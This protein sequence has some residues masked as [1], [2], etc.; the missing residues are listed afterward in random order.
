MSR[1]DETRPPP[2]GGSAASGFRA[3]VP[4]ILI[5]EDAADARELWV[6]WFDKAGYQVLCA[7]S[8]EGGLRWLRAGRRVDAMLIDY[9][10]PDGTGGAMIHQAR[11]S[12]LVEGGTPTFICTAYV[13]VTAPPQVVVL[14]KPVEPAVLVA[15]VRAAVATDTAIARAEHRA[16]IGAHVASA[17][18][19]HEAPTLSARDLDGR[20]SA[21]VVD[22][23][24]LIAD[25][26]DDARTVYCAVLRHMGYRTIEC[27]NG[28]QALRAAHAHRPDVVLTDIA[29][30][31]V[32][33]LEVTRQI[34]AD[35][36][37]GPTCVIVM[38]AFG[39]VNHAEAARLGCDAFLCKPF[40]PLIL[41]EL[42]SARFVTDDVV[43]RCGCGR[44]YTRA[45]WGA[46]AF[47]GT[48]QGTELR[49]CPCGSSIALGRLPA[50][51]R[52]GTP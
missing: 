51:R 6:L 31:V 43:K 25:D 2:R 44:E 13:H 16:A 33:G 24:V 22:P 12:G 48:M 37:L 42:L 50:R 46:L 10:L 1:P 5:V 35:P 45:Q 30:P 38:T 36:L 49:N 23:L 8:A 40:N 20:P 29:M 32:D 11:N 14:H 41:G 17:F 18:T 26:D 3:R 28:E 21:S 4:T 7:D 27:R 39:D 19:V 15:S 9:R 34:K 47:C 52:T